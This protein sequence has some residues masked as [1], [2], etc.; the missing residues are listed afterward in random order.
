MTVRTLVAAIPPVRVSPGMLLKLEAIDS[1]TGS[2][3]TGVT[4]SAWAI[5]GELV[6]DAGATGDP[7]TSGPFMLVPGPDSA[8]S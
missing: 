5:Y 6:D 8:V 2:A 7:A 4:A 1:T 3:V